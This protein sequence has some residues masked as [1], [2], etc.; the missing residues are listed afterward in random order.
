MAHVLFHRPT[1]WASPIQCSTKV[2]ARLT[3]GRGHQVNY[4]QALL[5]PIHLLRGAGGYLQ[6]WR[7][8]PREES[9]VRITTPATLVPVRDIR[10]LN[11]LIA[12]QLR[13]RLSIPSLRRAIPAPDLIWTT[14]P[15][16]ARALRR[17]FPK[18]RLVFHVVDYY[19]A[20]RGDAVKSLEWDDYTVADHICTIGHTLQDYIVGDLGIPKAKVSVLGQGVE[21][22]IYASDLPEPVALSDVSHPRAVWSGV[23]GKGDPLLFAELAAAMAA[24]KGSLVLIG[25]GEAWV[26]EIAERFP[27]TVHAVGA[28]APRDLPSWLVHCD[29]GVMLYDRARQDVYKGQN[30]LKLYEYAAAG[31]PIL[32]TPHDEYGHLLPPVL[33]IRAEADVEPALVRVLDP[34]ADWA[35]KIAAFTEDHSWQRKVDMILSRFLSGME[36]GG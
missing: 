14:V 19:P 32:S 24:R 22:E 21:Q 31:L 7:D 26:D 30:P 13:Y 25:P 1:V 16:S 23:L 9:G 35:D 5:D 8:S 6:V 2:L 18:A 33:E 29:L 4:L 15:G 36:M 11:S 34:A 17:S 3:A 20:F 28:V 12:A 10:P 27:Q